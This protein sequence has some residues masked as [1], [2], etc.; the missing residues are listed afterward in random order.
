MTSSSSLTFCVISIKLV[1][2]YFLLRCLSELVLE[3]K[4][5]MFLSL[6]LIVTLKDLNFL[7]F[8]DGIIGFECFL[9][10]INTLVQCFPINDFCFKFKIVSIDLE[11][12]FKMPSSV[13]TIIIE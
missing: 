3:L 5:N 1:T 12:Y 2:K 7:S 13:H 11:T 4:V 10:S 6:S 8:L 9:V